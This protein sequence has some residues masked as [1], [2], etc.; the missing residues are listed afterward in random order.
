M[1]GFIDHVYCFCMGALFFAL[2][3]LFMTV[4]EYSTIETMCYVSWR[5]SY[6][7]MHLT[8]VLFVK[9][10]VILLTKTDCISI[11]TFSYFWLSIHDICH[12]LELILELTPGVVV[13]TIDM[14]LLK[15][16]HVCILTQFSIWQLSPHTR[17]TPI[18][19]P[20]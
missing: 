9:F 16:W 10:S 3:Y 4:A 20:I 18:T 8:T 2:F 7:L 19:A 12:L 6:L 1:F 15:P 17:W 13:W 14:I 11:L 5:Y